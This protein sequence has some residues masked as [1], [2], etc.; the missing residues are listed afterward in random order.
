MIVPSPAPH[1]G[2]LACAAAVEM[3]ALGRRLDLAFSGHI[4]WPL[5]LLLLLL[6]DAL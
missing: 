3:A 5:W 4:D 1:R 2:S 6:L